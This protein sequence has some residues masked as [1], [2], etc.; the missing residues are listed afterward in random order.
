MS[1]HLLSLGRIL[2]N[3]GMEPSSSPYKTTHYNSFHVLFHSSMLTKGHNKGRMSGLTKDPA[4]NHALS[5][6]QQ[7]AEVVASS[8]PTADDRKS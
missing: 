4:N 2:R 3:E 7:L 8:A 6:K 5:E 1:A